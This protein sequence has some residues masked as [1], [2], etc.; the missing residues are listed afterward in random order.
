MTVGTHKTIFN[1]LFA[2]FGLHV[3]YR[4]PIYDNGT[5]N[6]LKSHLTTELTS[7]RPIFGIGRQ[8]S[9]RITIQLKNKIFLSKFDITLGSP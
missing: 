5:S 9:I 3:S 2:A 4:G 6:A 7:L 1:L 8:N